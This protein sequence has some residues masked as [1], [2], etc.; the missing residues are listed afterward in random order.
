MPRLRTRAPRMCRDRRQAY[1]KIEGQRIQLGRWGSPEA[2]EAYDR[3]IAEWLANG[4]RL[5]ESVEAS[6]DEPVTVTELCVACM[7]W[8]EER[9]RPNEASNF[10][11]V[12]RILRAHYGSKPVVEFGPR[13]LAAVRQAM[14]EKGW[15]RTHIN[16]QV[17]RLRSVFR[18][19]VSRELVEQVTYERLRTLEP[20][21]PGEAKREGRKV[22]PVPDE[23]VKRV[24]R[25]LSRQVRALIRLQLLT[26][27]RADELV[28]LRAT[29]LDTSGEVWT[30]TYDGGPDGTD[31]ERSHKSA[32]HGKQRI[33]FFGPRAQRILR[34]F[35]VP[36]RDVNRPL[37]SPRDAEAER[38]A[39]CR[40]HGKRKPPKTDRTLRDAYHPDEVDQLVETLKDTLVGNLAKGIAIELPGVGVL[41]PYKRP[42][43][44]V[45]ANFER[46]QPREYQ[47]GDRAAVKFKPTDALKRE[48]ALG[49]VLYEC[50]WEKQ[51]QG[52][53]GEAGH[54]VRGRDRKKPDST[55]QQKQENQR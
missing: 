47:T 43:R 49:I 37:F 41:R 9:H 46:G 29:D 18:W 52:R 17:S 1:V 12:V 39:K 4:R 32:H 33:V 26:G 36:G 14:V 21:R 28:R 13:S 45:V 53:A 38:Y 15:A 16:K 31:E 55:S 42:A 40:Y 10:R 22:K 23:H 5:P 34:R 44:K 8:V 24:W 35:M 3:L 6:G 20:L 30:V 48:V 2:Q 25:Y 11:S 27:A 54:S 7:K 19:G 51:E 50:A